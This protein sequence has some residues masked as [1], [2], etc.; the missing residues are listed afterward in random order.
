M[1]GSALQEAILFGVAFENGHLLDK[2]FQVTVERNEGAAA[3]TFC[4]W[5]S[6]KSIGY[7]HWLSGL[8]GQWLSGSLQQI[9]WVPAPVR[10][11]ERKRQEL[12]LSASDQTLVVSDLQVTRFCKT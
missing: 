1:L 8:V 7:W 10:E 9:S 6:M 5:S 12:F 4:N 2:Y 11:R 3:S